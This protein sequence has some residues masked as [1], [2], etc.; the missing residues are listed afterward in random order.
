LTTSLEA[1]SSPSAAGMLTNGGIL[2]KGI[3]NNNICEVFKKEDQGYKES[4]Q[5]WIKTCGL[6]ELIQNFQTNEKRELRG[7]SFERKR[8]SLKPRKTSPDLPIFHPWCSPTPSTGTSLAAGTCL[9]GAIPICHK[10]AL[11]ALNSAIL[12]LNHPYS[13]VR[14]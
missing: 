11:G 3:G 9:A 13:T 2:G 12:Q 10:R 7:R 4:V 6:Y 5:K 8:K 14:H 1:R